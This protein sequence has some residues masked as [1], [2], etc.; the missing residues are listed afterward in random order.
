MPRA[1]KQVSMDWEHKQTGCGVIAYAA[2]DEECE[3]AVIE[4]LCGKWVASVR[5]SGITRVRFF[6]TLEDGIVNVESQEWIPGKKE[7]T[8]WSILLDRMHH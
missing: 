2:V 1:R 6:D 7:E 5:D 4:T 8:G 3:A